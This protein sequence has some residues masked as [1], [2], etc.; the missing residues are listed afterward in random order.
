MNTISISLLGLSL[1]G[2]LLGAQA[3]TTTPTLPVDAFRVPL[4][5]D[6]DEPGAALWASGD[7]YKV[8]LDG[9]LTFHPLLGP[10]APRSLPLR[11]RTEAVS[12]GA[13]VLPQLVRPRQS[14]VDWRCEIDHG[15]VVE[16]YDVRPEGVEQTFTLRQRPAGAG[17]LVIRGRIDSELRAEPVAPARQDLVF[18]DAQ[19]RAVVTYGEAT[20]FDAAGRSQPV[21]TAYDGDVVELRLDG[22]WLAGATFPVVV[23]PIVSVGDIVS[24][25]TD[26]PVGGVSVASADRTGRSLL[27]AYHRTFSS[28]DRDVFAYTCEAGFANASRVLSRIGDFDDHDPSAAFHD[29]SD[30]WVVAFERRWS[31]GRNVHLY[32]HAFS[33]L[34]ENSGNPMS[35]PLATNENPG[36]PVVGGTR[37]GST[38]P[39]VLLAYESNRGSGVPDVFTILVDVEGH[40]FVGTPVHVGSS[41][42]T[43]L[44]SRTRP[45]INPVGGF[46]TTGWVVA[47]EEAQLTG[48][49]RI[50]G[51]RYDTQGNKTSSA[52]LVGGVLTMH[53]VQPRIAGV[54]SDFMLTLGWRGTAN[55]AP[56]TEIIARKVTWPVDGAPALGTLRFLDSGGGSTNERF[57]NGAIAADWHVASQWTLTYLATTGSGAST[58]T[59]GHVVR[60]GATGGVL[61]S[62]ALDPSLGNGTSIGV[63][64]DWERKRYPVAYATSQTAPTRH[65]LRGFD[66]HYPAGAAAVPYGSSCSLAN[67]SGTPPYAGNENFSVH[68]TGLNVPAPSGVL[69]VGGS[70]TSILLTPW[71]LPGCY[72]LVHPSLLVTLP[73][74]GSQGI[75]SAALPLP[76]APVVR[77]TFRCQWAYLDANAPGGVRTTRGLQVNVQ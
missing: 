64:F 15:G 17:D 28:G 22:C 37:R 10:S 58:Q 33:S 29:A 75:L 23:D 60:L 73:V 63:A 1:L 26:N 74:A 21:T 52:L 67:V 49:A 54:G 2:G 38:S 36:M 3:P 65:T 72:L 66:V 70:A 68:A 34:V 62:I 30:R 71:N 35:V 48:G 25:L 42:A 77:G 19:G 50:M 32:K 41:A 55:G 51:S 53:A 57:T 16:A 6:A 40:Q 39:H 24:F 46:N 18:R 61:E 31:T 8:R 5:D 45:A 59:R 4:H 47:W 44:T 13:T 20:A 14:H 12:V 11:W 43:L 69:L 9:D 7:A 56:V 27:V 76:D